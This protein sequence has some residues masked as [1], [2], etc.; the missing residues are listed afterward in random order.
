MGGQQ[1]LPKEVAEH[2]HDDEGLISF[3][4]RRHRSFA[5]G[6]RDIME[7][8]CRIEIIRNYRLQ[9]SG[10]V[11]DLG[12][13]LPLT[14]RRVLGCLERERSQL[15]M[16]NEGAIRPGAALLWTAVFNIV[17][18][19]QWDIPMCVQPMKTIAVVAI[20]EGLSEGE[21]AAAGIFAG[22]AVALLG[23]TG[24]IDAVNRMVP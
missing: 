4:R 2:H 20:T 18:A 16:A 11:G 21:V 10:M 5:Q 17:G 19:Y 7:V 15:A 13:L 8:R 22:G 9:I 1:R 12:T 24:L 6:L 23:C 3:I 14:V